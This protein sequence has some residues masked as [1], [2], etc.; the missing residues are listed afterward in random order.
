MAPT[1]T[2]GPSPSPT[3]LCFDDKEEY[4]LQF[5]TPITA[6]DILL[7]PT[8]PQGMA[9]MYLVDED[10]YLE[11]PCDATTIEQRYGLTTIWFATTGSNW[12]NDEGWLG[13]EQ[14]CNWFGVECA[15]SNMLV[16]SL[17]LGT[18]VL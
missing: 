12:R 8:T 2:P 10:P 9:F 13:E 15:L 16:T 7:D 4:I 18:C 14:E 1:I 11:N 5:L 6:E 17:E 3:E